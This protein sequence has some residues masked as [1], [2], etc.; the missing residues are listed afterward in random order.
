VQTRDR[1]NQ[2]QGQ[3]GMCQTMDRGARKLQDTLEKR[4][5]SRTRSTRQQ[6]GTGKTSILMPSHAQALR[7]HHTQ[8]PQ[9]SAPTSATHHQYGMKAPAC[10]AA[11]APLHRNIDGGVHKVDATSELLQRPLQNARAR[12]FQQHRVALV[13]RGQGRGG[14]PLKGFQGACASPLQGSR[15]HTHAA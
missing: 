9:P 7:P 15:T 11:K 5:K 13:A 12:A 10:H 3:T 14:D 2:R 6:E 4:T 8:T 1:G